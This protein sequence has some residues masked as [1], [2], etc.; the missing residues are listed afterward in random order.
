MPSS[1]LAGS[2]GFRRCRSS[3]RGCLA[4][5]LGISIS[6]PRDSLPGEVRVARAA[7]AGEAS[8]RAPAAPFPLE[9]ARTY[10]A[11][12][13]ASVQTAPSRGSS[14]RAHTPAHARPRRPR[15]RLR[16][17]RAHMHA[18]AHTHA[19]A[20]AVARPASRTRARS[21]NPRPRALAPQPPWGPPWAARWGFW[22]R[23]RARS[24][25]ARAGNGNA[26]A[27]RY[28]R[29]PA[30]HRRRTRALDRAR[31]A[32]RASLWMCDRRPRRGARR[33][34]RPR[35]IRAAARTER[36]RAGAK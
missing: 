22:S 30:R 8:Y 26:R 13:R 19:P 35:A 10:R 20:H 27:I 4:P 23:A 28:R 16:A 9:R 1:V 12:P 34:T 2:P 31:A 3:G 21:G 17:D 25:Q 5:A 18:S 33:T 7:P 6:L 14:P 29:P 32:D 11:R 36:H 15:A 24:A